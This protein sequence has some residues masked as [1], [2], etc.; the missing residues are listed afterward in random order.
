MEKNNTYLGYKD[1]SFYYVAQGISKTKFIKLVQTYS[2]SGQQSGNWIKARISEG[3][4]EKA[5]EQLKENPN[6]LL[7]LD[8]NTYNIIYKHQL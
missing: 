7:I 8:D 6:S 2:K 4:N 3:A 5:L 1:K